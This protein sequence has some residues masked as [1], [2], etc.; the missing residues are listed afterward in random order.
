MYISG[1]NDQ[2]LVSEFDFMA[3]LKIHLKTAP[4]SSGVSSLLSSPRRTVDLLL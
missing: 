2:N 3:G 1:K 4:H